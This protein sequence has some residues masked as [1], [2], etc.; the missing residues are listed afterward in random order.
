MKQLVGKTINDQPINNLPQIQ[1][2][3]VNSSF[4]KLE[5][6]QTVVIKTQNRLH[7]E[8]EEEEDQKLQR[9][10]DSMEMINEEMQKMNDSIEMKNR[11]H[12][13]AI[14]IQESYTE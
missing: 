10:L 9:T 6:D 11:H 5:H 1:P 3:S 12:E 14:V 7:E 4:E 8:E 13:N 2:A